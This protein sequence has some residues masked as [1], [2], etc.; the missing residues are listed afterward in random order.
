MKVM[1]VMKVIKT[2]KRTNN[3]GNLR[4][5]DVLLDESSILVM[6]ASRDYALPMHYLARR[7]SSS[8]S[9]SSVFYPLF[10]SSHHRR[11]LCSK[12]ST[13]RERDL[14]VD[15]TKKMLE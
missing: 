1:K 6:A 11:S 15:L 8:S 4:C 13:E 12:Q 10:S 2:N 14:L 7:S 3:P 9:S 5:V